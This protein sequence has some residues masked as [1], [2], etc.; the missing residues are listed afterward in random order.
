MK[1][2]NDLVISN[3][4]L[5]YLKLLSKSYKNI[6]EV[7]AEIIKKNTMLSIPKGTEHFLSDIHG[8]YEAFYHV[9]R[10][11]SGVIK[12]YINDLFSNQIT[13]EEKLELASLIYYPK[14]KCEQVRSKFD[15]EEELNEWYKISLY[16][17][18][19]VCKRVSAKYTRKRIRESIPQDFVYILE[20]LLFEDMNMKYKDE[21]YNKFFESIIETNQSEAYIEVIAKVI[22]NLAVDHLH[23]LGDIFDRGKNPDKIIDDLIQKKK[24]DIQ[25]GN[26]DILWIGAALGSKELVCNAIRVS[27]RHNNLSIIE[28]AYGIN[29]LPLAVF[30]MKAYDGDPCTRFMPEKLASKSEQEANLDAKIHKAIAVMQF[31]LEGQ[32]IKKRK[33]FDMENRLLFDKVS[34]DFKTITI[35]GK[36]YDMLD[37]YFPT[38]DPKDPY[39]LTKEEETVIEKLTE[40]F[41]ES[42]RLQMHTNFL[43]SKGSLYLTFNDNLLFHGCIPTDDNGNYIASKILGEQYSG[44]ILLDKLEKALRTGHLSKTASKERILAQDISW[45]LWCGKNSPLFGKDQMTTFERYFIADKDTHK[46]VR[47]KYYTFRADKD[48]CIKMLEDFGANPDKGCIINGHVPVKVAKGESPVIADGKLISIDGGFTKAYQ[49]VTGI[50]GYTL[51]YNSLGLVLAAHEPFESREKSLIDMEVISKTEYLSESS[52]RIKM[53]DT[54]E[55]VEIKRALE[56]LCLLLEAYKKGELKEQY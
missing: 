29:L 6:N 51:I 44:K 41:E 2:N 55:G 30:A 14:S 36:T 16:R 18:L 49:K 33:D 26:H 11:A 21:Y 17:I 43:L 19:T 42:V 24:V 20:E 23:I 56:N 5:E 46:E 53:R 7:S 4:K 52:V 40:S 38:V 27:A 1:T 47:N 12:S 9:T 10:N 54:D 35:K 50:A 32:L 22:H 13:T 37:S 39:K 48:F 31:K 15:N 8:E 45:Y 3:S 34:T 28:D 25:W